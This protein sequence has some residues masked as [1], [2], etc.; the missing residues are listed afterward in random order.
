[1]AAERTAALAPGMASMADRARARS[2]ADTCSVSRPKVCISRSAQGFLPRNRAS[3][4][5]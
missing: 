3:L 4:S 5:R 1:M 2:S